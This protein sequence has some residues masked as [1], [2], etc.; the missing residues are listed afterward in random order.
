M[1]GYR[2]GPFLANRNYFSLPTKPSFRLKIFSVN[3]VATYMEEVPF[4]MKF[5]KHFSQT[6][7]SACLR[8][9]KVG[10]SIMIILDLMV[11]F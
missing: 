11:E 9:R 10:N 7:I 4:K 6:C 2:K 5:G 3:F 8:K 1:G